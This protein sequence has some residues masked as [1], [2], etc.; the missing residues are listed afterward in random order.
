MLTPDAIEDLAD[1][2]APLLDAE[3]PE[4]AAAAARE[5]LSALAALGWDVVRPRV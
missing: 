3:N 5:V 4:A 1:Q 2:I